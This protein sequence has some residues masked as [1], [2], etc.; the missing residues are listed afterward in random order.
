MYFQF[1]NF[2]INCITI[3][4]KCMTV[5]IISIS[6]D[7]KCTVIV[8]ETIRFHFQTTTVNLYKYDV[9]N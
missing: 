2:Q 9:K 5:I 3:H 7:I 6:V 1:D 8:Y 4:Y